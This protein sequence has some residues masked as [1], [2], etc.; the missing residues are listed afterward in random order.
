MLE[1]NEKVINMSKQQEVSKNEKPSK[2]NA[3]WRN[4]CRSKMASEEE[5]MTL[6]TRQLRQ[7]ASEKE[8]QG[9][10]KLKYKRDLV[11]ALTSM[12]TCAEIAQKKG[13]ALPSPKTM[14]DASRDKKKTTSKKKK[15]KNQKKV[16]RLKQ[17]QQ[18]TSLDTSSKRLTIGNGA[19]FNGHIM[20][21]DVHSEELAYCIVNETYILKEGMLPN[22]PHGRKEIIA[23]CQYFDVQSV[24]MESTADYWRRLNW[25][26]TD[27]GIASLVAN[28]TQTKNT[29][30][31]KTDKFDAQ[32]IAVAHRDGRL[33]PSV[34]CSPSEFALRKALRHAD[35]EIKLSTRYLNR[36][37]AMQRMYSA[38]NWVKKLHSSHYGRILLTSLPEC[39]NLADLEKNVTLSRQS[40]EIELVHSNA[41]ELW[42][43]YLNLRQFERW[44]EFMREYSSYLHHQR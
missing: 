7:C 19:R 25:D 15:V 23:L 26:L 1:K 28:A 6:T 17:N 21:V 12:V 9:R 22:T 40:L 18:E 31:K 13:I 36:I 27:H 4:T 8:L 30:G 33:K 41:K 44:D 38:S 14:S 37:R 3:S 5:L 2:K 42:E 24:A 34:C 29:Q 39:E 35:N 10:S 20:G 16:I 32:R 11:Q 43:F